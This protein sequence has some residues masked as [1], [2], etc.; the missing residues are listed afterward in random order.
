MPAERYIP[1]VGDEVEVTV[2]GRVTAYNGGNRVLWVRSGNGRARPFYLDARALIHEDGL[3][4]RQ[5][6]P[7]GTSPP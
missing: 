6:Q 3:S 2:R 5:V 4:V 1:R 7:V